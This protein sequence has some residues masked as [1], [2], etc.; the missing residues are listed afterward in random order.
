LEDEIDLRAY[1]AVLLRYKFWI[2]G[3]ALVAALTAFGVSSLL[4][5]TYE[6]TAL[7][8]V[9]KPSYVIEFDPRVQTQSDVP[10]YRAYLTLALGDELVAEV[11]DALA[12]Q[13][14]SSSIPAFELREQMEVTNG[15]DQS[16]V[17]LSVQDHDPARAATIANLW[18][19][20]FVESTNQLYGQSEQDLRFFEAQLQEAEAE[21][22]SAEAALIAFQSRN[23][24]MILETQLESKR[25]ALEQYLTGAETLRLIVEDAKS[26]RGRLQTQDPT[27]RASLSDE[28]ASLFVEIE[29]LNS[30][31]LPIQL[32]LTGQQGLSDKT[33]GE[34]VTYLSSLIFSLEE[35]YVILETEAEGLEPAILQLQERLQEQRA[36]QARLLMAKEVA[37]ETFHTLTRKVAETRIAVQDTEGTV[38]LASRAAVP[39]QPVAPRRMMNTLIAG[40]LGG[41]VA[42]FGVFGLEYWQ[43]G[44]PEREI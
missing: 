2:V 9:A 26:L 5:P 27:L 39:V 7:V 29:S 10:S 21:L 43:S 32:Q 42:V 22:S 17:Q 31:E 38:R 12:A 37:Q 44:E 6:A 1:I 36:Q 25:A 13:L 34:Q 8:A 11:A 3:L 24:A 16:V 23:Q 4:A 41:F 19:E 35:K 40:A 20:L 28:I 18:T 30:E 15:T 33:V 14:P